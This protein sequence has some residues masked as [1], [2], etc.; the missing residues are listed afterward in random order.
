M[1]N[2]IIN[3]LL[4][5]AEVKNI[6]SEE[7]VVFL[8]FDDGPEYGITEFIL[9][10]LA[11][12]GFKAT[13]FCRGDNAVKNPNL[14]LRL[15]AEGHSIGNHS[16]SHIHAYDVIGKDYILDVRKANEVLK[17]RLF[18]PPHGSLTFRTWLELRKDYKIVFWALNSEDSA[19]GSFDFQHAIDNL[20]SN[21]KTGDVVLFHFCNKHEK[22]TRLLLPVYLEWLNKNGFIA[23]A[24][25]EEK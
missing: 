25:S 6:S 2:R 23:K 17:T 12:Y 8:T 15:R 16:Y 24:I 10:E 14:L 9:D 13:F 3:R 4:R 1:Y 5:Q 7:K 18:R 19:K 21:T 20:M 22:E 11:K